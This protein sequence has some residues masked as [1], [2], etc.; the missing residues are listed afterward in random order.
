MQLKQT[1]PPFEA[2]RERAKSS[3]KPVSAYP[4]MPPSLKNEIIKCN[5][6]ATPPRF[7]PLPS[8]Q[9]LHKMA[10]GKFCRE[11]T[12]GHQTR[13]R[14]KT[15]GQRADILHFSAVW[16]RRCA[17]NVFHLN[18]TE[19]NIWHTTVGHN[20]NKLSDQICWHAINS[21]ICTLKIYLHTNNM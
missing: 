17:I 21:S 1:P 12:P 14:D 10:P 20:S 15:A 2:Q 4:I 8:V 6:S 3:P 11:Q 18:T 13:S 16:P 5:K 9:K 19:K 7:L